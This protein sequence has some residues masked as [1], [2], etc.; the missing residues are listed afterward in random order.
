MSLAHMQMPLHPEAG[1]PP[2]PTAPNHQD[3][4]C[5]RRGIQIADA[6]P[7]TFPANHTP[8]GAA[9]ETSP[10]N[11]LTLAFRCSLGRC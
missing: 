10:L 7:L 9:R 8:K 11:F 5:Q 2:K 1:L 6:T 3:Q 4:N